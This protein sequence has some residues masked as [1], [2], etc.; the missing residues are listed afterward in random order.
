LDPLLLFSEV[1]KEAHRRVSVLTAAKVSDRAT[2]TGKELLIRRVW[3]ARSS[4]SQ[5]D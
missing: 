3:T 5:R 4:G 2:E 1:R